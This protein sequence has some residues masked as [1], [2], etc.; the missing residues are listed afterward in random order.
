MA[1]T[2]ITITS[3]APS[4]LAASNYPTF[5]P[6]VKRVAVLEMFLPFVDN[7]YSPNRQKE[8]RHDVTKLL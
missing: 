1:T 2:I 4:M 3:D 7:N 5:G 6:N 8:S